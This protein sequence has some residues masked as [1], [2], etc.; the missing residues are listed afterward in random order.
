MHRW[1]IYWT[2]PGF[3]IPLTQIS[4]RL[5]Q[6][7]LLADF[8]IN[9]PTLTELLALILKDRRCKMDDLG[10]WMCPEHSDDVFSCED[11][12]NCIK[13]L[14]DEFSSKCSCSDHSKFCNSCNRLICS[15][16]FAHTQQIETSLLSLWLSQ[17]TEIFFWILQLLSSHI[18]FYNYDSYHITHYMSQHFHRIFFTYILISNY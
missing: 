8:R 10:P 17:R 16:E 1:R 7:I 9:I 15:L 18:I 6:K 3:I 4:M 2:V 11:N 14:Y 13:F 5:F 12:K